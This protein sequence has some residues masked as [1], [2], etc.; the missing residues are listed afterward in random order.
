MTVAMRVAS[1]L[2]GHRGRAL[3]HSGRNDDGCGTWSFVSCEPVRAVE[4]HGRTITLFDRTGMATERFEADPLDTLES[5]IREHSAGW[6]DDIAGPVPVAMGYLGYDL[7]RAIEPYAQGAAA[8]VDAVPDM[9]IGLYDAVWRFDTRTRQSDIVGR[10]PG[11][12]RALA[13]AIAR[14]DEQFRTPPRFGH[15]RPVDDEAGE[16]EASEADILAA[17]A[18][19]VE[20]ILEY[21]RAGD[22]YQVNL[23][24]RLIAPVTEGGDALALYSE[25]TRAA[26]A[27]FG[28]CFGVP[29]AD[30][31]GE[32]HI[33]S[34]SPE[35]FLCREAGSARLETRPIKG[36]RRRTGDPERD[37]QL[38]AELAGDDKERAEHLMIVDLERNDLGRIAQVGSV[39]VDRQGYIVELPNLF[40]MVSQVSC[41]LRPDVGLAAILRATYPSGSITGAPKIRAMEII[42]EL[43]PTRRGPY[44][45]ALGYFGLRGGLDLSIA[46]RTALLMPDKLVLHV[47]GGVVADSTAERE[48]EE[49]E[50]KAAGWR[51]ALRQ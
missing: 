8:R 9:W 5:L 17:Y 33:L 27:P 42:D 36:T 28:A 12:R 50:E 24:R 32:F 11:A 37:R 40:H 45:G 34:G 48:L 22:V 44:T 39:K 4:A 29:A 1:R 16:N 13:E 10:N 3:L 38:A 25:L 18:G 43:E 15:L 47:G 30:G 6:T 46:I 23:A 19:R 20:R 51:A 2:T 21:I 26:P 41:Q 14:G 49:T 31:E 7:S 35:R